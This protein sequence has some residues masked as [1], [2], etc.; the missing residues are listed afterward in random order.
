MTITEHSKEACDAEA[1]K[2]ALAAPGAVWELTGN[3][4]AEAIMALLPTLVPEAERDPRLARCRLGA[5]PPRAGR[6]S[7]GPDR[8]ACTRSAERASRRIVRSLGAGQEGQAEGVI[9]L[10]SPLAPE[11]QKEVLSAQGA[12]RGLAKNGKAESVMDVIA[13]V[14]PDAQKQVLAAEGAVWE[15]AR[16]GQAEALMTSIAALAPEAQKKVLAASGAVAGLARNG[17]AE[18]IERLR[19]GWK[20]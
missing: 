2:Q 14:A 16:N 5:G 1:L 9:A 13:A 10:I 18:A 3:G 7:H 4:Q 19:Q 11:A 6:G 17:Q 20:W 15:L 8:G 12:V